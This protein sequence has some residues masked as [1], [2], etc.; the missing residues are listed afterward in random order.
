M[1]TAHAVLPDHREF[2][3]VG[4]PDELDTWLDEL[5]SIGTVL[6]LDVR[7]LTEAEV[8]AAGPVYDGPCTDGEDGA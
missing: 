1:I 2:D 6:D 4:E 5:R 7:E 3:F 8:N